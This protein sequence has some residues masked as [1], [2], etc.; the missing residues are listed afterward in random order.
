MRQ[1]AYCPGHTLH[2]GPDQRATLVRLVRDLPAEDWDLLLGNPLRQLTDDQLYE[3]I[4]K[5]EPDVVALLTHGQTG[6]S[7]T[8]GGRHATS[9]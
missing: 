2:S 5:L 9:T 6:C 1:E 4:T 7:L 8:Q 3:R